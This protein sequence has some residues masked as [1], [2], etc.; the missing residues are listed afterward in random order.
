M[1]AGQ[2]VETTTCWQAAACGSHWLKTASFLQ[3]VAGRTIPSKQKVVGHAP[4]AAGGKLIPGC[5]PLSLQL[6]SQPACGHRLRRVAYLHGACWE[7]TST[8]LPRGGRCFPLMVKAKQLPTDLHRQ[9]NISQS[10]HNI[11]PV[12]A[13]FQDCCH[14]SQHI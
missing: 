10:F 1:P 7:V 3:L 8:R 12:A 2:L 9:H 5:E 4:A 6:I 14:S 11:C 13:D